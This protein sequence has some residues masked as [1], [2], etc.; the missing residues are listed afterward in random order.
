M[1]VCPAKI[2]EARVRF[3]V[4]LEVA[5][6]DTEIAFPFAVTVNLLLVAV[7]ADKVSL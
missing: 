7:V 6:E 4:P 1:T 5:T 3:T 2:V